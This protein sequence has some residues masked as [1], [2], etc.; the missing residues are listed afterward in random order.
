MPASSR[1]ALMDNLTAAFN[2]HC[3]VRNSDLRATLDAWLDGAGTRRLGEGY[4]AGG[5][6]TNLGKCP[7]EPGTGTLQ[8]TCHFH[9]NM[10]AVVDSNC[11]EFSP[12]L[13]LYRRLP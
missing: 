9:D 7:S 12:L 5:V 11:K 2:D 3:T 4:D 6:M 10:T 1:A 13:S 8:S